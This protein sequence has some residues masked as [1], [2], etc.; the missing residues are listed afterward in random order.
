MF[1]FVE[2]ALVMENLHVRLLFVLLRCVDMCLSEKDGPVF[3]ENGGG[4]PEEHTQARRLDPRLQ[5]VLLVQVPQGHHASGPV[6]GGGK[7]AQVQR[8]INQKQR[9]EVWHSHVADSDNT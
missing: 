4:R 3:H 7:L 8:G 5:L 2:L 9:I 6:S 1:F